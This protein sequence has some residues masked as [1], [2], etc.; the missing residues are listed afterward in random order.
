MPKKYFH[1]LNGISSK[2]QANNGERKNLILTFFF[3]KHR[4]R[5]YNHMLH[6]FTDTHFGFSFI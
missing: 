3:K 5:F 6:T 4:E 2:Q 1:N